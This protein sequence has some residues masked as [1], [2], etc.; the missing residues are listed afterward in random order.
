MGGEEGKTQV[1]VVVGGWLHFLAH[2]GVGQWWPRFSSQKP[3]LPVS[4]LWAG[5]Q[6][7]SA[8][9][10]RPLTRPCARVR[11]RCSLRADQVN[12]VWLE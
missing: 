7:A 12:V 6:A 8:C 4:D 5:A 9:P 3:S 10:G 1:V 11:V 2:S